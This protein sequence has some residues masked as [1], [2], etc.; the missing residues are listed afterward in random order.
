MS[1]IDLAFVRNGRGVQPTEWFSHGL[2]RDVKE[3]VQNEDESDHAAQFLTYTATNC[4]K[5]RLAKPKTTTRLFT[6]NKL[7]DDEWL[8]KY[9]SMVQRVLDQARVP[10]LATFEF[11]S[12]SALKALQGGS[13]GLRQ[14]GKRRPA[15]FTGEVV[16]MKRCIA[17]KAK[18]ADSSGPA[19]PS[20]VERKALLL[21]IRQLKKQVKSAVKVVVQTQVD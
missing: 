6:S 15:Y 16:Q 8:E 19:A 18:M 4:R 9:N 1:K 13:K 2:S 20:P 11:A 5:G 14:R 21:E 3:R 10:S 12:L 7:K 17:L